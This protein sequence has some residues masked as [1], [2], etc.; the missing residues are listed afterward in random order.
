MTTDVEIIKAKKDL[1]WNFLAFGLAAAVLLVG[2]L[3]GP[4]GS[5]AQKVTVL[6]SR[7]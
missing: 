5:Y 4:A 1:W 7:E 2:W 6:N 3:L